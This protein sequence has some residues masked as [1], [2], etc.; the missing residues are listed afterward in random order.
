MKN[1]PKCGRG[2]QDTVAICDCGHDFM[3]PSREKEAQGKGLPVALISL[4]ALIGIY[5]VRAAVGMARHANP[6]NPYEEAL[7]RGEAAQAGFFLLLLILTI[8]LI[9]RHIIA[10]NK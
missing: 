6:G 4:A 10:N 3:V 7:L 1:C 2:Q 9:V 8:V 5:F